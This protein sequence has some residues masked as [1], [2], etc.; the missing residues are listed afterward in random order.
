M[1]PPDPGSLEMDSN[2]SMQ[3]AQRLNKTKQNKVYEN[4]TNP[5]TQKAFPGSLLPEERAEP[6][7][8]VRKMTDQCVLGADLLGPGQGPSLSIPVSLET[9]VMCAAFSRK[10]NATRTQTSIISATIFHCRTKGYN[11]EQMWTFSKD[12]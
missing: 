11:C 12:K 6:K 4:K 2:P 3:M 10:Y 8:S 1:A 5:P 9:A 7:L